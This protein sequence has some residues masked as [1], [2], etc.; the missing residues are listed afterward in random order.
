MMSAGTRRNTGFSPV[1]AVFRRRRVAVRVLL[2]RIGTE[3]Q[4]AGIGCSV[5]REVCCLAGEEAAVCREELILVMVFMR[6]HSVFY[7]ESRTLA[8][9]FKHLSVSND[10]RGYFVREAVVLKHY[11]DRGKA[12]LFG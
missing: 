9:L 3:I 11:P 12:A 5:E 1:V 4:G 6:L 8:Q 10:Y 2:C 7:P